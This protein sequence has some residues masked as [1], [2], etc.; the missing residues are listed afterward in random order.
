MFLGELNGLKINATGVDN[1]YLMAFTKEKLHHCRSRFGDHQ[2]CLLLIIKALYG[3]QASGSRWHEK[4]ADTT[5]MDMGFYPC[6]ADPD[7]WMKNCGA[8]Y[9]FN[10]HLC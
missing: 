8:D 7:V 2:G 5:L 1:A 9:E 6:K 3:L 4:F 10:L